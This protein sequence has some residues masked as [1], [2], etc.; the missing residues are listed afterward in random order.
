MIRPYVLAALVA[1]S[2]PVTAS[3][4]FAVIDVHAIAQAVQQVQQLSQQL[5]QLKQQY[6][7]LT[8][9]NGIGQL[10]NNP[11]LRNML[12]GDWRSVYDTVG[13]G[14]FTGVSGAASGIAAAEKLTG[15]TAEMMK[16]IQ[17]R[18]G[19][20]AS[21]NKAMGILSFD[22]AQARLKNITGLLQQVGL[23]NDTKTAVDL[24]SRIAAEQAQVANEATK[25]Q[26]MTML[27][28]NEQALVTKQRDDLNASILNPANGTVASV[29]NH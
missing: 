17:D 3:A 11:A 13:H 29:V 28:A 22:A 15:T 8:G 4:Q 27:Q 16:Q 25:L 23:T 14:G 1:V 9:T 10:L 12:P 26:L 24:Q 7:A 21:T 5:A 6:A 18:Q 19:N 20:L 2:L